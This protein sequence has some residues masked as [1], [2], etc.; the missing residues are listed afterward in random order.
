[1]TYKIIR[2]MGTFDYD[3]AIIFLMTELQPYLDKNWKPLG[4]P[5]F[6]E[7]NGDY[8]IYQAITSH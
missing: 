4:A 7:Y 1:M 2:G 6:V 3:M 8:F 5:I